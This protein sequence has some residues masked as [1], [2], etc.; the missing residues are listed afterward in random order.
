MMLR[1]CSQPRPQGFPQVASPPLALSPVSLASDV[2]LSM[3]DREVIVTK[4]RLPS[5]YL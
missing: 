5:I 2:I 3:D 4:K 1:R